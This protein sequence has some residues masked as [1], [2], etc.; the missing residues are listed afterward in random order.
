MLA[1]E[2]AELRSANTTLDE[3][4]GRANWRV[5][6]LEQL[7][8]DIEVENQHLTEQLEEYLR[9]PAAVGSMGGADA[10]HHA[11][12]VGLTRASS[13]ST[14]TA[15]TAG[16]LGSSSGYAPYGGDASL[17]MSALEQRV[18]MAEA[19]RD[20]LSAALEQA[21]WQ[22]KNSS[23]ELGALQEQVAMLRYDLEVREGELHA[24]VQRFTT[25]CDID[26]EMVLG[27]ALNAKVRGVG[28]QRALHA[29]MQAVCVYRR[30][31][32]TQS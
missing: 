2:A 28:M 26:P 21:S 11:S 9:S 22:G 16:S 23:Q 24:V 18:A 27:A 8:E 1:D 4:L 29:C 3:K 7:L 12:A 30:Q 13:L 10:A 32:C 5:D 19:R 25:V 31:L 14:R 6:E 17:T 15:V 20:E